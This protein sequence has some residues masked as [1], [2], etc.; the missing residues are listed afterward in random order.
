MRDD[1]QRWDA[2]YDFGVLDLGQATL[3][4]VPVARQVL[5]SGPNVR[6]QAEGPL[7]EWPGAAPDG[8]LVL[9]LRRD[10]VLEVGGPQR[11][12]GWDD[13][14]GQAVSDVTDAYTV[15]DLSGPGALALLLRGAEVSPDIPSRSVARMLFDLGVFLYRLADGETYRLHVAR[16]QAQTLVKSF[17]EAASHSTC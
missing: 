8:H 9:S 11:R 2:P 3:T 6:K 5:I 16:A 4:K 13:T 12:D 7:I 1:S 10:R 14:T 17:T 15:F